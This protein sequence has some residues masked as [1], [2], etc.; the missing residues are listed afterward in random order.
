MVEFKT[1]LRGDPKKMAEEV[2]AITKDMK[3][4]EY[5][6][7]C[8]PSVKLMF[9]ISA[10]VAEADLSD[11]KPVTEEQVEYISRVVDN[12]LH[13]I[14]EAMH[15]AEDELKAHGISI[16]SRTISIKDMLVLNAKNHIVLPWQPPKEEK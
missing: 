1:G 6:V 8:C 10:N 5:V 14:N 13:K 12:Y 4:G 15:T 9:R 2:F 11:K 7:V 16:P 3:D